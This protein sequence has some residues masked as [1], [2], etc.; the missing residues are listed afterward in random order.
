MVL[1]REPLCRTCGAPADQVDHIEPFG[2]NPGLRLD[3]ADLQSLCGRCHGIKTRAES[4]NSG[5]PPA[6]GQ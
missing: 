6:G 1:A 5:N 2:D 4:K 3:E